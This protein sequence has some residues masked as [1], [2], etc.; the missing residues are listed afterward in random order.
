VPTVNKP[1]L[2]LG[3]EISGTVVAG[4]DRLLG[5]DVLVP[6]VMPCNNCPICD[7]G[8]GNRC[9]DQKMPGN[10]LGMYG[11]FADYI[12]VPADDLCVIEDCQGVP[13]SHYSVI[14]DAGTTPYQACIRAGI[15]PGDRVMI[16]GAA[17]GVG[18]YVTQI[19]KALGA[20]VVI[21][22]DVDQPRLERSAQYGADYI[23]DVKDKDFK[24]LR[25]E[26][27]DICKQAGV[28][29][30]WGWK[31]FE[32]TGAGPAQDMALALLGFTGK[33]I[34]IG[35]GQARNTY[36]I[37]RLMAFDAEIIGTWGCLP[38]YYPDVLAMVQS[39]KVQIEP[40]LETKPMGQIE[41]VF[42]KQHHGAFD[43]RQVLEPDF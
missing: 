25:G 35:F 5:K 20:D 21:G 9:L 19:S 41:D 11:G 24:T 17:G 7:S 1:P 37:S 31:T 2:T 26:F 33:L 15:G 43:K 30:N 32:A 22:L 12:P 40:F 6:A 28:P 18:S 29:H 42:D 14:A 38:K 13:L 23:I 36:S 16:F 34:I 39:G 27:R 3:H 10:S 4:P 8:R